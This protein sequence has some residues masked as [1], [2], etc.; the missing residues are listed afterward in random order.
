MAS[1]PPSENEPNAVQRADARRNRLRVLD[2]ADLVFSAQG[3]SASTEEVAREAG[4]GIGT[5]FRH[6]PTKA[7]LLR[8]VIQ[9]RLRRFADE[10]QAI[11]DDDGIDAGPAF[12]SLFARAVDQ[13]ASKNALAAALAEAGVDLAPVGS[14]AAATL[15]DALARLLQRAQQAGEVRGDIGTGELIALLV[16]ASRAAEQANWN[17]EVIS[18]V[19]AVMCA[20]LRPPAS[21]P[22][23]Q[24]EPNAIS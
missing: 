12:F 22:A 20:G 11:A 2:A 14:P 17:S 3:V 10:A 19:V 18:R 13:S 9:R 6:F 5:V 16:G 24:I 23:S 21:A 8:A 15:R 7:D 1:D 4:V